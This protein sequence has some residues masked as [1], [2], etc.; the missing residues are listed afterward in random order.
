MGGVGGVR[1]LF[2]VIWGIPRGETLKFVAPILGGFQYLSSR[3]VIP[4]S[5]YLQL[6]GDPHKKQKKN[7]IPTSRRATFSDGEWDSI[8]PPFLGGF[9]G[10]FLGVLAGFFSA[11]VLRGSPG[12][13]LGGNLRK[14]SSTSDSPP[15]AGTSR[16]QFPGPLRKAPPW[17]APRFPPEV[18]PRVTPAYS[19]RLS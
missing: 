11:G 19:L 6:P 1:G 3:H 10:G 2:W 18:S 15:R 9:L 12:G 17:V 16:G 7:V 8:L 5:L 13:N 14:G 4:A